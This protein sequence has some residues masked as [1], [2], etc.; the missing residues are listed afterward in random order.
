MCLLTGAI[1]GVIIRYGVDG[2]KQLNLLDC[3]ANST[4]P[5]TRPLSIVIQYN[6]TEFFEYTNGRKVDNSYVAQPQFED[7]VLVYHFLCIF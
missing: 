4:T 7:K 3:Y 6:Y 2:Q 5:E 1:I